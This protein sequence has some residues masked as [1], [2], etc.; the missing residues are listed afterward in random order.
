MD[1]DKYIK[2]WKDYYLNRLEKRN[3]CEKFIV[4]DGPPY[5]NDKP[6]MGHALTR[7]YRDAIVKYQYLVG[8]K[9]YF[10]CGFD[11]HGLPIENAV[12]KKLEVKS[13]QEIVEKYGAKEFNRICHETT[14]QNRNLW[15]SFYENFGLQPSMDIYDPYITCTN[16]YI[17]KSWEVLKTAWENE[18]L[19]YGKG[20][21]WW[22]PHCQ[23]AL[24]DTEVE[25]T[26][27][28]DDSIYVKFPIKDK[29]N[30]YL[31]IWTTTP[32]TLP[33]NMLIA[34]NPK[35]E[36]AKVRVKDE[37][38]IL[39]KEKVEVLMEKF[40]IEDYEILET[41]K[42][43]D[44]EYLEYDHILK[45][46]YPYHKDKKHFVVLGNHVTLDEGTGLVHTAPAHG[47]DDYN[48]GINYGVDLYSPVD[49]EGRYFE[50]KY[51]GTHIFDANKIII[52]DL[53]QK[54]FL[55][56]TEK[57]KHK[58]PICWRCKT[59]LISL[60]TNEWM[61][62]IPKEKLLEF[63]EQINWVP[64]Y[65]KKRFVDWVKQARDWIL[66]RKRFWGIPLPIWKCECGHIEVIGSLNE[67]K[68]KAINYKDG[69]DLHRP[70]IDEIKLKCPK[71][72]KEMT[73]VEEIADVWFDSS[74]AF[75]AGYKD[76]LDLKDIEV[77]LPYDFVTEGVDQINKWFYYSMFSCAI[78]YE[79]LPF[80]TIAINE[81]VLDEKGQK[82][83][84]SKGN[85][86]DPIEEIEKYGT[87]SVRWYILADSAPW[88]SIRYSEKNLK[89]YQR[90]LIVYKN[91]YNLFEKNKNLIGVNNFD[92][93]EKLEI[94]DL[95]ILS[96]L[97]SLKET[98]KKEM[99]NYCTH[100]AARA[101]RDFIVTDLS[102]G[103]IQIV[104]NRLKKK[105]ERVVKVLYNV[106]KDLCILTSIFV[107]FTSE[108][109]YEK[110]GLGESVHLEDYPKTNIK[111]LDTKLEE[112]FELMWKIVEDINNLRNRAKINLRQ[113]LRK[114]FVFGDVDISGLEEIICRL[115]NLKGLYVADKVPIGNYE[116]YDGETYQ[117]YLDV[118]IDEELKK[119][120]LTREIIRRIQ[121]IRKELKL[122]E[123]DKI[124]CY[125][126]GLKNIDFD[127][128]KDETN[129]EKFEDNDGLEKGF[130]IDGKKVIIK[131]K[132]VS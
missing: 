116:F 27:V 64:S 53:K 75:Y 85:G 82:M 17:E 124:V 4:L 35:F 129:V 89:I 9:V 63:G 41:F 91:V 78:M 56:F 101:L 28:V 47:Q 122:I 123:T 113:P 115:C 62:K 50:G 93:D 38:W 111:Y 73:R 119:E 23:T 54:G 58:Y 120:G 3:N 67:L 112:K 94:E 130:E 49:G 22:C 40:G 16:D 69:L 24:S 74:V 5:M 11:T 19:Y 81:F 43:S 2:K 114:A 71:C 18:Y 100:N 86:V 34:V 108:E 55:V 87:D 26:E 128:I 46:E 70:Y 33:A 39:A 127:R 76:Y 98:V 104:R 88:T 107:P 29:E 97:E 48:V 51:K 21:C 121:A 7:A 45:E 1:R 110:L 44:L 117:I 80:K 25:Y 92:L 118:E 10:R 13:K 102:R 96:K 15:T 37:V 68:E 32:W 99:D 20:I 60:A 125:I 83:S 132:K 84:K 126:D 59:K 106:L 61:L 14:V 77:L 131:I 79:K 95:W 57:I 31:V 105:D 103:Y 36:Y 90:A 72:G 42:G 66:S 52:E 6:H 109:I 8:K 65:Y 30:E 12:E